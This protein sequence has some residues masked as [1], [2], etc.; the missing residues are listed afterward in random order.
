LNSSSPPNRLQQPV[1]VLT[2][3]GP[4]RAA[5][6]AQSGVQTIEDLFYY[7]PRRYLDRST[8][9]PIRDLHEEQTATVVGRIIQTGIKTGRRNRFFLVLSDETSL[10]TCVWFVHVQ[11]WQKV[12]Q[13]GEW[14]AVSGKVTRFGTFQMTHPE[15]DLLGDDKDSSGFNTGKIVP[16]YPS[17]EA[18]AQVGLDSRGFRRMIAKLC[19]GFAE[20]IGETLPQ[21]I[22][23]RQQLAPLDAALKAVH[24]P[25]SFDELENVRRRLKFDELFFL[26]LMLA[27]RKR[28]YSTQSGGIA[29][30]RVGD[31]VKQLLSILPFELTEAQKRV[32][33]EIRADMKS[34][35]AMNRLLQGDVGSGKT[36]VALIAML[37][38]VENGYQAAIMAPTEILAEQHYLTIHHLLEEIGVSTILLIGGQRKKVRQDVLAEIAAG[39]AQIIVGTHA[40][41]QENV[42]FERLGL[43]IID[44][45]H[46][47]GVMQRATLRD[48][49]A[50]PDLLVMT[51]TPIPRTLSMTVY[52]DLDVSILDQ[53]PAGRKPIITSWRSGTS[54]AKIY[55][56]VR[57]QVTDGNQAYVVFP[58]VEE[59]EKIDLKAAVESYEAMRSDYFKSFSLGLIHGR[60]KAEEK[61]VVMSAFKRGEIDVLVSTTVIEVGVD[62]PNASLMVIEHAERFGL[63]QLHQLR[64][65]VGRGDKQSYCI[66]IAHGRLSSEARERLETMAETT[67]GFK[68]AEKDLQLRGPGDYFGTQQSGL[69]DFKIANVLTDGALLAAARNEAFQLVERDPQLSAPDDLNTR[70]YFSRR[71][72][73]YYDLSWVS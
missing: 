70:G 48:K 25:A 1:D 15:F 29:F 51:A 53:L 44:E 23:T 26:E 8:V 42:E 64:G 66:L 50:N 58:L 43:V 56:F 45:Q 60:M 59:S 37:I 19:D 40:L 38:A 39:R 62:V 9:T 49:G 47:F 7:F 27:L 69:P 73:D 33:H 57:D 17:S 72:R 63:T 4:K 5:A 13:P 12:F 31:K 2:S 41:I 20:D 11:H 22:V 6:L 65:R 46:R 61:E 16:V 36:V 14:L 24:F 71:Y 30:T 55:K 21:D 54:R 18:L 10:L 34:G 35:H 32:L 3:I 67:D 52:G 28:R 68:I